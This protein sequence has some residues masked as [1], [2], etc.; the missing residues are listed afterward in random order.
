MIDGNNHDV[1]PK[2]SIQYSDHSMLLVCDTFLCLYVYKTF[3]E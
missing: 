3:D 1:R 2:P